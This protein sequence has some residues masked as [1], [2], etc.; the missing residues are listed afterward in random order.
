MLERGRE[1]PAAITSPSYS[2]PTAL[3]RAMT[4]VAEKDHQ[5]GGTALLYAP[6]KRNL[7]YDAKISP[8]ARAM[9]V[10]TWRTLSNLRWT[11]GVVLALWPDGQHLGVIADD[12]RTRALCVVPN[13]DEE[14]APWATAS[15]AAYLG[16]AAEGTA[17]PERTLLFIDPVVVEGLRT[18][19]VRVNHANRLAGTLD[20]R[21][22]VAVLEALH[23]G[24]YEFAA[25]QIY[26]WAVINGWPERG[27]DR[28]RE[29]AEKIGN[30]ARPH[31]NGPWPLR[32]DILDTWRGNASR[33]ATFSA[34]ETR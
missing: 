14:A 8:V 27:A 4:W 28:L 26:K 18:L 23:D 17:D 3:G 9:S 29:L 5:L 13:D 25:D 22:A 31:L 6:G 32:S 2:D 15:T 1:Y 33:N 19:T 11:G 34:K 7:E 16:T 21:D 20:R 30:G 24:G 10:A 12:G